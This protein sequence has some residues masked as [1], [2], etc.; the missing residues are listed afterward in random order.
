MGSLLRSNY[1]LLRSNGSITTCYYNSYG[2]IT[3]HYLGQKQVVMGSLLQITDP[4]NLQMQHCNLTR[5]KSLSKM[6]S[7]SA[8]TPL[9]WT[10]LI[11]LLL[12]VLET[13]KTNA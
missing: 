3:T 13:A 2:S 12:R 7:L 1:L 6:M 8:A 11:S 9:I 5:S 10:G 4:P